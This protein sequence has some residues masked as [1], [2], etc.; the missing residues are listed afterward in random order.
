MFHLL[1]SVPL[2]MP[3]TDVPNYLINT[4]LSPPSDTPR[5]LHCLPLFHPGPLRLQHQSGVVWKSSFIVNIH[6]TYLHP[7]HPTLKPWQRPSVPCGDNSDQS[8][9]VGIHQDSRLHP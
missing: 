5:K 2:K 3:S 8:S 4:L 6:A 7:I 9:V 1:E